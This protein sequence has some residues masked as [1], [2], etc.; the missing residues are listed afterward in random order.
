MKSEHTSGIYIITASI[1]T[2][3]FALIIASMFKEDT[4]IT[5]KTNVSQSQSTSIN[6]YANDIATKTNPN[7]YKTTKVHDEVLLTGKIDD[8]KLAPPKLSD[9]YT[10][11]LTEKCFDIPE[12]YRYLSFRKRPLTQSEIEV[13]NSYRNSSSHKETF[14]QIQKSTL[15]TDVRFGTEALLL[16]EVDKFYKVAINIDGKMTSGFIS[17]KVCN[18]STLVKK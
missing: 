3:I 14:D 2:G 9:V 10:I 18:V 5:Q 16:G 7:F 8:S 4:N 13:I 6:I 12:K 15:I 1:I 17:K 11:Y